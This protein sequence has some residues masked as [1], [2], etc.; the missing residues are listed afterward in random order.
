VNLSLGDAD[1]RR[2]RGRN[3][4]R[5]D[6]SYA[7]ANHHERSGASAQSRAHALRRAA[8]NLNDRCAPTTA[9]TRRR[10]SIRARRFV[11]GWARDDAP[12]VRR[13]CRWRGSSQPVE[14]EARRQEA[15]AAHFEPGNE[16]R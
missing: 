2:R 9:T 3:S 4:L 5:F 6:G 10:L 13:F 14:R 7:L 11:A 8:H 15:G 1:P 16:W 12:N